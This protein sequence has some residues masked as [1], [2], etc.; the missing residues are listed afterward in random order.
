MW[1][2]KSDKLQKL[3]ELC[4]WELL[5]T[6]LRFNGF[7]IVVDGALTVFLVI[8]YPA[9]LIHFCSI[10]LNLYRLTTLEQFILHSL[11]IE[12]LIQ[13]LLHSDTFDYWPAHHVINAGFNIVWLSLNKSSCVRNYI[14]SWHKLV[15]YHRFIKSSNRASTDDSETGLG[16]FAILKHTFIVAV[17][18]SVVGKFAPVFLSGSSLSQLH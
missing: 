4:V 17:D 14:T 13:V 7:G 1:P 16:L 11:P 10:L 3:A 6:N 8:F 15:S 9:V 5:L 12:N 2:F 18:W